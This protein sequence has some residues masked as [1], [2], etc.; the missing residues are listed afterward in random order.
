QAR[1]RLESL[2][3]LQ[4]DSVGHRLML[5]RLTFVN[6]RQ[7]AHAQRMAPAYQLYLSAL[8][9]DKDSPEAL[10]GTAITALLVENFRLAQSCAEHLIEQDPSN[11]DALYVSGAA[12][13]RLGLHGPAWLEFLRAFAQAPEVERAAFLGGSPLVQEDQLLRMARTTIDPARARKLSGNEDPSSKIDWYV[14]LADPDVRA[15]ILE[16]WWMRHDPSPAEFQNESELEYWTR[17]VEADLLF[18]QPE[19][20]LRG[21]D[22]LPGEVWIRMGRPQRQAHWVTETGGSASTQQLE[23]ALR[24]SSGNLVASPKNMWNWDY[25]TNGLW[26]T[27][28]FIDESY[29]RPNWGVGPA[30]AVDI[31]KL[32]NETPFVAAAPTVIEPFD[33]GVN[34]CRFSRGSNSVLETAISVREHVPA[35]S[36]FV[37]VGADSTII[38]WTLS[39]AEG[40]PID[41]VTRTLTDRSQ[42]SVLMAASG[43]SLPVIADDPRLTAIGAHVPPGQYE[44]R[45]R[46]INS[47]TGRFSAKAFRIRVPEHV[48]DAGLA[49]S[50]VQLSHGLKTWTQGSALPLEFVKHGRSVLA[51]AR[52]VIEGNALGVYFELENLAIGDNGRT[53]FDVEYAIYEGTGRV[54]LLAM[55][56]DFNRDELE[57]VELSTVQYLHEQ[58]GVSADGLV[59]KGTEVDVSALRPGDYVL[60]ITVHDLI[61]GGETAAAVAFRRPDGRQ[62]G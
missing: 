13:E 43:Q 42:L 59:V 60:L 44:I 23:H 30:S 58:T 48:P 6:A 12:Q 56:G 62:R 14:V 41:Q 16:R 39:N 51:S 19:A 55:L 57:E 32:R 52:A 50:S 17:L 1:A 9:R 2:I 18:A 10:Y 28:Q 36:L 53:D 5:A 4:P 26:T 21:W 40:E 22:V 47:A 35:D 25:R 38:E 27:V 15:E 24:R 46:A 20:G 11:R 37:V 3:S 61:A 33:L 8:A 31:G 49:M 45:V 7:M 29:G 34:I 54:R